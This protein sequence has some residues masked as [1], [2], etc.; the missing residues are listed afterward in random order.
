MTSPV[1][2][3]SGPSTG[4]TPGNL[5]KG[6]TTP[7]TATARGWPSA[8]PCSRRD[9]PR[10][11]RAATLAQLTP[12]ALEMKGTVRLARGLA[13][14]QYGTPSLMA[15]C[16]LS[17]PR[18]P[19]RRPARRLCSFTVARTPP[20]MPRGGKTAKESPECTPASSMCAST[21]A[22]ATVSPSQTRSTSSSGAFSR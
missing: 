15:H 16:R 3:I 5:A 8:T 14:R 22:M 4:S 18:T 9:T 6:N 20:G 17:R 19:V 12:V 2:R 13:S 7:F 21:P 10:P 1:E 11:M